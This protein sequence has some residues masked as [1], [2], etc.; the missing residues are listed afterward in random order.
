M[1]EGICNDLGNDK[2]LQT[3]EL[4]DGQGAG[5]IS[6]NG[7]NTNG[8]NLHYHHRN[9]GERFRGGFQDVKQTLFVF[10][11]LFIAF[12][13]CDPEKSDFQRNS[14]SMVTKFEYH[15]LLRAVNR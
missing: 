12:F 11:C 10:T 4:F 2:T 7:E 5:S 14:P 1:S 3:A 15:T 13:I 6:G 9:T 8:G